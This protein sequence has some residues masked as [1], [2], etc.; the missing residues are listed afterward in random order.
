VVIFAATNVFGVDTDGLIT[1]TTRILGYDRSGARLK[2]FVGKIIKVLL[3]K[4]NLV[5][6]QTGLITVT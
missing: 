6:D 1:E 5:K 3:S 2:K 4:K